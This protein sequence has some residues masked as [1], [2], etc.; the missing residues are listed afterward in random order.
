MISINKQLRRKTNSTFLHY[1][2]PL[3]VELLPG[4][5]IQL[6]LYG[7]RDSSAVAIN[8]SDLYYELVRRRVAAR[9]AERVK[10]RNQ[11]RKL[12]R[13]NARSN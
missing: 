10:A 1:R 7:Q 4:D 8:I 12:K 2:K 5:I 11:K 9:R 13:L 3:V 6:R